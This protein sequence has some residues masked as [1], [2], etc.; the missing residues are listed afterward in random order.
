VGAT[1]GLLLGADLA[2]ATFPIT[3]TFYQI[4]GNGVSGK[5][6]VGDE[7]GVQ[8]SMQTTPGYTLFA[9]TAGVPDGVQVPEPRSTTW[10]GFKAGFRAGGGVRR[11]VGLQEMLVVEDTIEFRGGSGFWS[12]THEIENLTQPLTFNVALP[13]TVWTLPPLFVGVEMDVDTIKRALSISEDKNLDNVHWPSSAFPIPVDGESW[14][15][16]QQFDGALVD[17]LELDAQIFVE[18]TGVPTPFEFADGQVVRGISGIWWIFDDPN[19]NSTEF[20]VNTTTNEIVAAVIHTQVGGQGM[21]NRS[22]RHHEE[23]RAA[24]GVANATFHDVRYGIANF[25]LPTAMTD[26]DEAL[27]RFVY[28]KTLRDEAGENDARMIEMR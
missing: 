6:V 1:L 18:R 15:H 24:F 13:P 20:F 16:S 17:S 21:A 9:N 22:S 10:G 3:G 27:I 7:W 4:Q 25:D 11:I 19:Q 28:E 12:V 14:N 2:S 5:W 8:D 26:Y 23:L